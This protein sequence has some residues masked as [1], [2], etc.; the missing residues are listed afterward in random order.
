MLGSA[1]K[2]GSKWLLS[3][4]PGL[5]PALSDDFSFPVDPS[6]RRL[7]KGELAMWM[8]DFLATHEKFESGFKLGDLAKLC[9][10]EGERGKFSTFLRAAMDDVVARAPEVAS[11]YELERVRRSSLSWKLRFEPGAEKRKFSMPREA[12]AARAAQAREELPASRPA[13]AAGR[14]FRK[15]RGGAAL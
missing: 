12:H 14:G 15:P 11:A 8:H 9:G 4:D 13:G 6:R 10:F 1:R 2:E 3:L 5:L 7:L